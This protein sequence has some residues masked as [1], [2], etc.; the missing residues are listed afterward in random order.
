MKILII[1][2]GEPDY[3]LDSL[4]PQG[5]KE[6]DLLAEKL[7]RE[8]ISAIYCSPL[9]RA[10]R[11]AEPTAKALGMEIEILP[12][13][14]EFNGQI[15]DFEHPGKTRFPWNLPPRFWM[16]QPELYDREAWKQN[17]IVRE[18]NMVQRWEETVA[19]FNALLERYGCRREESGLYRCENN[20]DTTIALFCHFGMG[21]LLVGYLAHI[22]PFMMWQNFFMPTSSVTTLVTEE[23]EKGEL[24]FKCMQIGDTSHLYKG[25]EAVSGSGL[26]PEFFG[27]EGC[28]PQV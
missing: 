9:G 25:G 13:L 6:V 12:W 5:F 2:H 26:Y 21:M 24:F 3:A 20:P 27:G 19:D 28:G 10:Q 22:S 11:T 1:R 16:G 18:G 14:R 17:A 4:T 8:P 15:G 23:R 7:G